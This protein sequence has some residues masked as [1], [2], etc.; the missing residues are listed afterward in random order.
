[1]LWNNNSK[2]SKDFEYSINTGVTEKL[3]PLH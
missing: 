2:G 3:K 1:M